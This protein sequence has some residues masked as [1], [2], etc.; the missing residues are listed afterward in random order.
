MYGYQFYNMQQIAQQHGFARF[1]AMENHYNLLYREDERELIPICKQMGVSLMPYSPLAAGHLT[2][3]EWNTDTL[4]SRTDRVAMGKYDHTEQQDMEI[5]KRV[6]KLAQKYGV[7]MQQIALAWHFAK[8]VSAP[9][10]GA[11]DHKDKQRRNKKKYS[12]Y[13]CNRDSIVNT[14]Y[15]CGH[16]LSSVFCGYSRSTFL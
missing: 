2:R 11:I 13:N 14:F 9:I 15:P 3:P 1:E 10:I 7:K 5:V 16:F 4:R 6:D 12:V 8:G